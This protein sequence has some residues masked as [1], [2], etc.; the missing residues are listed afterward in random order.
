MNEYIFYTTEG[1]TYAP[2][3]SIEVE[4]C[5]VLGRA[6]GCNTT[7]GL[8]N[9]LNENRWIPEAGFDPEEFIAKQILTDEQRADIKALIEYLWTDEEKHYEESEDKENHIFAIINRLKDL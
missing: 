5:Q 9:L 3:D 2:N 8:N 7:E 4:N 6:R 1:Q